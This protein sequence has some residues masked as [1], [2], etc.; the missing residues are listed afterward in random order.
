MCT[1]HSSYTYAWVFNNDDDEKKII[2]DCPRVKN[3]NKIK[4]ATLHAVAIK[5]YAT[6]KTNTYQDQ[7]IHAESYRMNDLNKIK[8]KQ[9]EE[10]NDSAII[11]R[12]EYCVTSGA[13]C[14]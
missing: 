3:K 2:P 10:K 14:W 11:K 1:S 6:N 9:N 4:V 7:H 8:T 13:D 5:F 12:R